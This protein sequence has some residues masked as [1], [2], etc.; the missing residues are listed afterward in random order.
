MRIYSYKNYEEYRKEVSPKPPRTL[1]VHQKRLA[2]ALD[3]LY[4]QNDYRSL[5]IVFRLSKALG[6]NESGDLRYLM[7][8]VIGAILRFDDQLRGVVKCFILG[9]QKQ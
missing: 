1:E 4:Q 7:G 3:R 9:L 6:D 8:E 2:E 5:D